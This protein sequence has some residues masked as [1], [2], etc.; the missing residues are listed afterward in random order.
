MVEAQE[1]A[2]TTTI[3]TNAPIAPAHEVGHLIYSPDQKAA[4]EELQ[5]RQLPTLSTQ[6]KTS[7]L[8]FGDAPTAPEYGMELSFEAMVNDEDIFGQFMDVSDVGDP[9]SLDSALFH[10]PQNVS[11]N[12]GPLSSGASATTPSPMDAVCHFRSPFPWL[13]DWSLSHAKDDSRHTKLVQERVFV[14]PSAD[15]IRTAIMLYFTYMQP[16]LPV[17][18]ECE[19]HQ[20]LTEDDPKPIS[21]ALLYAIL[22]VTTPVSIVRTVSRAAN[23]TIHQYLAAEGMRVAGY[24]SIFAA[25]CEFYSRAAVSGATTPS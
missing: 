13:R 24:N 12:E 25:T 14:L 8:C 22:F 11:N 15:E 21:L 20:L 7:A 3:P 6:T 5:A 18:N 2:M 19:F 9:F 16:R 4:D 23:L 17:L 1:H 10:P